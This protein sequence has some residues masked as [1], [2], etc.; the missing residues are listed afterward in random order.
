MGGQSV[1]ALLGNKDQANEINEADFGR[2][3]MKIW[4]IENY[5]RLN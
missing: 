5:M 2:I 4:R 3:W 1:R